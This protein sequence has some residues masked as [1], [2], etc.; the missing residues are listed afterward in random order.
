V[1]TYAIVLLVVL[2][3]LY[4]SFR[5]LG[6]GHEPVGVEDYRQLL[7][8]L[9][10]HTAE[11]IG[12][13]DAVLER[14]LPLPVGVP[15]SSRSPADPLVEVGAEVRKQLAGYRQRLAEIEVA[16]T[17]DELDVLG[18]ARALLT[19]AIE[20]HSWVC[21]L[22]EGGSYRENP[23]IQDA[24]AAL[25]DHAARCMEAAGGVLTG[26]RAAAPVL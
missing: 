6:G 1:L 3:V 9:S 17:G 24:V 19:A 21:R 23:G 12:E 2:A 25:R 5:A 13:L 15:G 22:L 26:D 11:R 8:R 20:D 7:Q 14:P 4:G 10:A 16:A 18:S